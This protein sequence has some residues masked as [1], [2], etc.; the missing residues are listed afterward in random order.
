MASMLGNTIAVLLSLRYR[1]RAAGCRER[2]DSRPSMLI[3]RLAQHGTRKS[4][5]PIQALA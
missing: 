3:A 2:N 4:H 5:R 1:R